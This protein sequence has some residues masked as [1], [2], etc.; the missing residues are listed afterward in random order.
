MK[1]FLASLFGNLG[2]IWFNKVIAAQIRV[3]LVFIVIQLGMIIFAYPKL[4]PQIPLFFSRPW[5]EQ[6]LVQPILI[7]VLPILSLVFLITNSL[8]A[9]MFLDKDVFL[10][11]LLTFGAVLFAAFSTIALV[12]IILLVTVI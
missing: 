4:P 10:S 12:K 2:N 9:S 3:A 11:Q 1:L 6:Q 7:I 5:G 8:T